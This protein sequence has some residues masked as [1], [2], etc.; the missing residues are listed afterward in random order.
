MSSSSSSEV[1]TR[2]EP[3]LCFLC[4]LCFLWCFLCFFLFFFL[5]WPESSLLDESLTLFFR[6]FF[7]GFFSELS[8]SLS[9]F[10]F[11]GNGDSESDLSESESDS[12]FL[13]ISGDSA[14]FPLLIGDLER[15]RL[16]LLVLFGDGVRDLLSSSLD[17]S[18]E[19]KFAV[20]FAVFGGSF[21]DALRMI[22]GLGLDWRPL[23]D[24]AGDL[25]WFKEI[26]TY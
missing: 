7:F 12:S 13:T 9:V 2:L 25:K 5:L 24:C 26:L 1:L 22:L 4:F 20:S 23:P 8:L 18:P 10:N 17:S 11:L 15:C 21:G 16:E 14:R 6:F 19:Y 3:F